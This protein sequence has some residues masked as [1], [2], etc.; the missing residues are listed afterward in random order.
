MWQAWINMVMGAWL[1]IAGIIPA[2][3]DPVSMFVPGII[4]IIFGFWGAGQSNSWQGTINGIIGIWLA[5]SGLFLSLALGWNFIIFGAVMLCL[6]I[7]NA[8]EHPHAGN[9]KTADAK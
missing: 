8:G 9:I 5:I 3:S 7:W 4:A 2:L 6:A 1:I